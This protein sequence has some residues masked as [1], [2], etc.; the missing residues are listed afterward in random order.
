VCVCVCV[1]VVVVVVVVVVVP[2][3][4]RALLAIEPAQRTPNDI[5]NMLHHIPDSPLQHILGRLSP[6]TR[7]M[8]MER[9]QVQEFSLGHVVCM[10]VCGW[11]TH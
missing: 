1:C 10:Q 11:A 5:A 2:Y 6:L 7:A 4:L 8:I 3:S 9:A